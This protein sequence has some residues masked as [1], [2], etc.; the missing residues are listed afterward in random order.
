M[1]RTWWFAGAALS[2]LAL[3]QPA[4]A[5]EREAQLEEIVVTA[6]KRSERLQDIG[7]SI[8][9][10]DARALAERGV[11]DVQGLTQATPGVRLLEST[12]GGVPVL[13]I[14]GIGLQDFRINNTPTAAIYVDEVYQT[15]VAQAGLA[16][17]DLERLELLKGPQGGLYGRNTTA[18]AVQVISRRP[19]MGEQQGYGRVEAGSFGAIDAEAAWNLPLG[20]HAAARISA[21]RVTSDSGYTKAMPS[22]QDHGAQDK[23][24]VRGLV[25]LQPI[26]E[27]RVLIKVHAGGDQSE[28]PLL[29]PVGTWAPGLS[30]TPGVGAGAYANFVLGQASTSAI[31]P[32]LLAG[33]KDNSA[34]A[35]LNGLT[36]ASLGLGNDEHASLGSRLNRLGNRWLGVSAQADIQLGELE[37]TSITAVERFHVGRDTD[38]TPVGAVQQDIY[39]R[40]DIA[41]YSQ[42]LRLAR[43]SASLDWLVGLNLARDVLEEDSLLHAQTGLVPFAYRTKTIRQPYR[44]TTAMQ[45]VYGRL[46]WRFTDAM[47]L[48]GE[49]RYTREQKD[50]SGGTYLTDRSLYLVQVDRSA[51]FGDY[52]GKVALEWKPRSGLLAYASLSRGYKSG[53]FFGGFAT[54][55]AQTLP[56]DPE[57]VLAYEAGF[58]SD[59]L[60]GRLRANGSVFYYDYQGLQGFGR[61]TSGAVQ[62]QR[63]T[64][65]GD[66]EVKG[67][68]LE[69]SLAPL[70]GLL[71]EAAATYTSGS[72]KS[73]RVTAP[74][75]FASTRRSLE[76]QPLLNTPELSVMLRAR[77]ETDLTDDLSLTVQADYLFNGEQRLGYIIS[78]PERPLFE[79]GAYGLVG[80]RAAIASA[81]GRWEAAAWVKNAADERYRTTARGDSFGGFFEL[82]GP[83]RTW[84]ASL[85][86]RF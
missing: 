41:A 56:Y 19:V 29:R 32:A 20:E 43:R 57:I 70:P 27:A 28:T 83:P 13:I 79:E 25:L 11:T 45:S 18:G 62:I 67:A 84:G 38:W 24:A 9:A 48:V 68:E 63:L 65:V 58:K 30:A 73:S 71:L 26:D 50:F 1:V 76:G 47:S 64:N 36:P 16:F 74:D 85:S 14:R 80:A 31:C 34:C 2:V 86:M 7:M 33:R 53:G 60:E 52:S 40:S 81:A 4:A 3:A 8:Q 12:G 17:F 42:E 10:F 72:I 21:R 61:E 59:W 22:G 46:D 15:S 5:Q 23:W 77:Y 39:Y 75:V 82:Y 78:A 44:Q 6:Q 49:L 54:N 51:S 37:L 66:A 55:P 35:M 69:L